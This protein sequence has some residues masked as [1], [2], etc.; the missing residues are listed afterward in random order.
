MRFSGIAAMGDFWRVVREFNPEGIEREATAPIDLCFVGEPGSGRHTVANALL[1]TSEGDRLGLFEVMD[2]DS[3]A[4][5]RLQVSGSDLLLLVVRLDRDLVDVGRRAASLFAR[6]RTPIILVFT[7]ADH[8]PS[9]RDLRNTAFR[10]FSFVSHLRTVFVNATDAME[11]QQ[12]LVPLLL[13]AMPELRTSLARKIPAARGL[14]AEQI[15]AETCRVNAQFAL[16]ANL[17]A[18]LPFLGSVAGSVADFFVLT[19]NQVMMVLR[20]A[21]IYGRDISPTFRV[22][23]EIAPVIG[24]GLAWR[25]AARLAVGLV[26]GFLAAAPK[27]TIAYVG[28]YIAGQ[29]ARYYYD[30]GHKPPRHLLESF[31]AEGARLFRRGVRQ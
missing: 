31:G 29:A 25:T 5:R 15:I 14:V 7:H 4:G 26:P 13:E 12:K 27:M 16:A 17:P 20:L 30:H 2:L 10:A 9:T 19:K 8:I 6:E 21:A 24:G 28:T 11:V 1:G 23:A 22:A 3:S 18:N